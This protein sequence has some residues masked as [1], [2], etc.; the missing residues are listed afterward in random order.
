MCGRFQLNKIPREIRQWFPPTWRW[1]FP[2]DIV[3]R[4]NIAPS[5]ETLVVR[6]RDGDIVGEML[7]WGFRP[8]WMRQKGKVQINARAETM[9][10][11]PMF[12]YSAGARRCLVIADGFYEPKG[13][14]QP[15]PWY[16]FHFAD[17]RAFA[18]GGLWTRWHGDEES[19]DSFTIVTTS[20]NLAVAPIHDRM[21]LILDESRFDRWLDPQTPK[22]EAARLAASGEHAGLVSYRVSD[23]AKNPR[24]EGPACIAP[25]D[26]PPAPVQIKLR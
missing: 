7:I 22:D 20:A 14:T 9:F 16:R 13:K 12:E 26:E 2:G 15:R 5:T 8:H 23:Y 21:P 6:S 25:A 24:N 4:F 3:P 18:M 1:R 17:E 10:D 11:T 19:Y